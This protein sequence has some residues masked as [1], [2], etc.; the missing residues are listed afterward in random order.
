[1]VISGVFYLWS[2]RSN[3][4]LTYLHLGDR[5]LLTTLGL[6]AIVAL[7][8]TLPL[9]FLLDAIEFTTRHLG[10]TPPVQPAVQ[11]FL[12]AQS[13]K[14]IFPL[15]LLAILVAPLT[16]EFLFR[17]IIYP[18]AKK[19]VSPLYATLISGFLFAAIHLHLP[20]FLPLM[21]LGMLLC[22]VLELTGSLWTGVL[23]HACFNAITALFLCVA[24][25]YSAP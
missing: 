9:E 7:G 17:G 4:L 5:R 1:M 18:A 14:Q 10:L 12:Q 19:Y 24:K 2:L 25:F 13:L 3:S 6:A 15:L 20:S 21:L 8:I 11:L 16:E 23:I 22:R